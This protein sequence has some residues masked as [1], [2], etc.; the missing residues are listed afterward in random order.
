MFNTQNKINNIFY[1]NL[2]IILSLK[3]KIITQDLVLQIKWTI[4]AKNL[5]DVFHAL[6]LFNNIAY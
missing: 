1:K 5:S 2:F 4:F 6:K 3:F